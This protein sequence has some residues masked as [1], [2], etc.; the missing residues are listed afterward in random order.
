MELGEVPANVHV[1]R[2][3]PQAQVLADAAAIVC[4][5]GAGTTLGALAAGVPAVFVPLFA[6][7]P[8]NAVRAAG[9]GAGVVVT[10]DGIRGG[11]ERVLAHDS[12][13]DAARGIA[14]S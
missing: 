5:G 6:D 12:Y 3:V 14:P 7:Q 10:L 13:R 11:V 8:H 1:E 9:A 4:H 2:W